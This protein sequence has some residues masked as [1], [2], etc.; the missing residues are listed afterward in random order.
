M[1]YLTVSVSVIVLFIIVVLMGCATIPNKGTE[2]KIW[3]SPLS[4]LPSVSSGETKRVSNVVRLEPDESKVMA[5]IQ[6][7]GIIHHI[8]ITAMQN[9]ELSLRELVLRAYWDNEP[10]PSVEVPLGD[11]FGVGFAKEKEFISF[12]L[13]MF[14]AG[15]ENRP[16][17]NCYIPMPF[18][19]RAKLTIENQ[20]KQPVSLMFW[21][22]NYELVPQ[23]GSDYGR[24]HAQWRRENPVKRSVPYT[25]LEAKGQ[26]RY[27]GTVFNYHLLELGAWVEGGD[28][29]YIDVDSTTTPTLKGIGAEDY[30]GHAWGFRTEDNSLFH[31]TSYGPIDNRMTAYRF[32]V[33]DP[34]RF[35]KSIKVTM[36]CH[37]WD[38]QDREDDYS[39]IAYWYQKEPHLPFPAFPPIEKRLP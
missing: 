22:I 12:L 6:G 11:F 15:G 38:V 30:F 39:S 13:E 1:K 21:Q 17:L 37:G 7:I 26:G 9:S 19:N 25:I 24:F 28:D 8:W 23:I 10:E 32:H 2:P 3:Q 4:S 31:G 34:I 36:R 16:A 27:L 35:K 5:D 14:P 29:F 20:G 18:S 33:L